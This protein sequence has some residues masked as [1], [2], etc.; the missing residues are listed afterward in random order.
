MKSWRRYCEENCASAKQ[1]QKFYDY[2]GPFEGKALRECKHNPFLLR[3]MFEVASSQ[4]L[5]FHS[6]TTMKIYEYYHDLILERFDT[7]ERQ[8][9]QRIIK[10][11]AKAGC[12][13]EKI[14][15]SFTMIT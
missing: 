10:G 12:G 3:I 11:I 7:T 5:P 13:T 8:K 4:N 6:F 1:I 2:R 15:Q 14:R 9:I